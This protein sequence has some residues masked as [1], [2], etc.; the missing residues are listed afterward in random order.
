MHFYEWTYDNVARYAQ[1]NTF[2]TIKMC[3]FALL[4]KRFASC[5]FRKQ[6]NPLS[7][8]NTTFVPQTAVLLMQKIRSLTS[9]T[10]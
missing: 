2:I 3:D 9:W 10:P 5:F 8:V 1:C 7:D 4:V 6:I